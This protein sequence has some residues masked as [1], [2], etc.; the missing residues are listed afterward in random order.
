MS[1][2][3]KNLFVIENIHSVNRN[4]A[5]VKTYLLINIISV[6]SEHGILLILKARIPYKI[7]AE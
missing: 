3:L 2:Y 5:L 7:I 4:R 6:T 1:T